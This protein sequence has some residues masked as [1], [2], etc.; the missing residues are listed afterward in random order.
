MPE[1]VKI[2]TASADYRARFDRPYIGLIAND[3][4]AAMEAVIM[5]LLP[6]DFQGRN[7]LDC[8]HE[9]NAS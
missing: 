9:S 7:A 6:F 4:L 8:A 5:A 2:P 1:L 3:R